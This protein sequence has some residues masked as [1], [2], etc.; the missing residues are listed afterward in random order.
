MNKISLFLSLEFLT[1]MTFAQ[2]HYELPAVKKDAQIISHTAYTLEYSEKDEQAKWVAYFL[3]RERA[4]KNV[5]RSN[6]FLIDPKVKTGSADNQDYTNSGYDRGHLAPAADMSWSEQVMRESF[7]YSNMSPQFPAFNR[8]IWKKLEEL[9]RAWA[10]LYDTLY[11]AT[12]PVLTEVLP[13]IG[14]HHVSVPKYYYKVIIK[15]SRYNYEGIGFI[16]PNNSSNQPLSSFAVTI[17]EVEEKTSIDF[18]TALPDNKELKVES[19]LCIPCWQWQTTSSAS[20]KNGSQKSVKCSA[21]TKS[22]IP[23]QRMTT[24]PNGKCYQH[25]GN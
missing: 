4:K 19:N 17:D 11:I 20:L 5:E 13:S 18:F 3:T 9:V 24:S 1:L 10:D 6:Q 21:I 12:G 14:V 15:G 25:G 22:G 16:I 2:I 7:Y 23:C 8:G